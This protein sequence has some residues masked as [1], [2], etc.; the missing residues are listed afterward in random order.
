MCNLLYSPSF[1][2]PLGIIDE[3]ETS[4]EGMTKILESM[5]KYVPS[6]LVD[7]EEA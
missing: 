5:H 4:Y 3:N 7:I 6:K 2:V 1:Q